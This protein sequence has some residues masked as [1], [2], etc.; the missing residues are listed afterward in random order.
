MVP[1]SPDLPLPPPFLDEETQQ[2]LAEKLWQNL[3]SLESPEMNSNSNAAAAANANA[4]G[5]DKDA[6]MEDT[7]TTTT[8]H[9]LLDVG[10]VAAAAG[11]GNYDA[12]ED[13]LNAPQVLE[14]VKEFRRKLEKTQGFQKKKRMELVMK[15]VAERMPRVKVLMEEER[16]RGPV[17]AQ[18]APPP[19]LPG[20]PVP[21]LP[22]GMA[23]TMGE[24]PP[25][26]PMGVPPPPPGA[27][28]ASGA[29]QVDSG[30]RGRSNLPAWMTNQPAA[31][32]STTSEEEPSAKRSKSSNHPLTFPP[33]PPSTHAILRDFLT[34][35]IIQYLGEE[36]KTLID[37][38][39]THIL[40]GKDTAGLVKELQ[41][42]LE[43][44]APAF[45]ETLWT[46]IYELQQQQ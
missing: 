41:M 7:M 1:A 27:A 35:Q 33:L 5:A 21:G 45:V 10:K 18:M 11:G 9:A 30:K 4:G 23:T 22:P 43:E 20:M 40:N 46:K 42:V 26:L 44:E 3:V 12:D 31:A 2:H 29:A 19:P 32:A 28:A 34:Q 6:V 13:P 25:P 16:I 8:T 17:V 15:K 37:F 38:L 14:A 24:A 39:H 36:E